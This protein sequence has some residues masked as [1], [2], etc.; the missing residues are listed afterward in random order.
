MATNEEKLTM[1]NHQKPSEHTSVG[2]PASASRFEQVISHDSVSPDGRLERETSD[3]Q[4][5][6][7]A[8][9]MEQSNEEPDEVSLMES[10]INSNDNPAQASKEMRQPSPGHDG[11]PEELHNSESINET[12]EKDHAMSVDNT[13]DEEKK[14]ALTQ[15]SRSGRGRR[16]SSHQPGVARQ[17]TGRWTREEHQLFLEGLQMYGREWKK[18]AKRIKTRTSAQIRSHAQKYFDKLARDESLFTMQERSLSIVLPNPSQASIPG[19]GTDPVASLVN[20]TRT[21]E[22]ILADPDGARREVEDTMRALQERYRQLQLRLQQRQQQQLQTGRSSQN[23]DVL[24]RREFVGRSDRKR[25]ADSVVECGQSTS[26][27]QMIPDEVSSVSSTLTMSSPL[28]N[29]RELVDEEIIAL[30]VLGEVLADSPQTT[31]GQQQNSASQ[32]EHGCASSLD[33]SSKASSCSS[34]TSSSSKRLKVSHGD[35]GQ[36]DLG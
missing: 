28:H 10:Q 20:S 15:Q 1:E 5:Q 4:S 23:A 12:I 7:R 2:I 35:T 34:S 3:S 25:L 14:G 24:T 18:V 36:K 8:L 31:G 32:R 27:S 21:A 26:S 19:D 13:N 11:T 17:S 9:R 33:D 22:R 29:H 30:H 16:K 6:P